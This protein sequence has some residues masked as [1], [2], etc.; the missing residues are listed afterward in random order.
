MKLKKAWYILLYHDV[1][2][3]VNPL[4]NG[5]GGTI[6]PDIFE[7]QMKTVNKLGD[8]VSVDEGLKMLL[9][10][11]IKSPII[12]IWFDD[13]LIGVRKNAYDIIK[14]Y[15]INP[16]LSISSK[17]MLREKMFWR[18]MTSFISNTDYL[19]V[20]RS[21][22]R[23][24]GFK[25]EDKLLDFTLNHFNDDILYEIQNLY[26][27]ICPEFIQKDNFRVFDDLNGITYLKDQGWIIANHSASH[28]PIGENSYHEKFF[29]EF[30]ECDQI[31]NRLLNIDSRY[32]VVPFG[33]QHKLSS[34]V[35]DYHKQKNKYLV[36][37]GNKLNKNIN[38]MCINRINVPTHLDGA[39]FRRFLS[40]LN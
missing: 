13:G 16:A 39:E 30:N 29:E 40:R 31:I 4:I 18:F 14:P 12:S 9:K 17:F 34:K 5:I 20:L 10:N 28:Y 23:K 27:Q 25:N 2:Y 11:K 8:L 32:W 35:F 7:D 37:V 6:S 22:L 19:R 21:R 36:L 26:E 33:R 3:E 24:Y 38:D 1:N 15:G